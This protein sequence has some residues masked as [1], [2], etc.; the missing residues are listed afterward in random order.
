M[1]GLEVPVKDFL[2]LAYHFARDGWLVIDALLQHE[3]SG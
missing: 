1:S 2:S 3:V